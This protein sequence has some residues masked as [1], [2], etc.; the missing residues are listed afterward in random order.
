[1]SFLNN[2]SPLFLVTILLA[3]LAILIK[4][5]NLFVDGASCFAKRLG[6]SELTIGLT[7]V[8]LGTSGPELVVNIFS[9][10]RGH[11]D[12]VFGN[13][14][15]SNIANT[16]LVLGVCGV[17]SPLILQRRTVVLDIPYALFAVVV[18]VVVTND[19][20][21]S[22]SQFNILN[23]TEGVIL[24]FFFGLFFVTKEA[25]FRHK[26]GKSLDIPAKSL[27]AAVAIIIVGMIGMYIG[28]KFTVNTAI[29]LV[30]ILGVSDKLVGLTIISIGTSLPE[31]A[32]SVTAVLRKKSDIAVGNIIGSNIF[33]I[34]V[35][36]GISGIIRRLDYNS[37][38]NFDLLILF[39]V[40]VFIWI[41]LAFKKDYKF[42][43]SSAVV[44]LIVYVVYLVFLVIRK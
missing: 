20:F 24:I 17:I 10:L 44:L 5:A 8:A 35:V 1:M 32:A 6:I 3:G 27:F 14:I 34:F 15:G 23:R 11:S 40:S 19:T 26:S 33:N 31:L 39:V 16:M 12:L 9:S 7:I 29:R 28:G 42:N 25:L 36:L 43:K 22:G 2:V 4:S 13:I 41:P 18:L 21:F 37:L 38:L 30:K